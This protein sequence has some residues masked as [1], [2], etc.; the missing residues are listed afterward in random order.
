MPEPT[1]RLARPD[2][3]PA[4]ESLLRA[5]WLPPIQI[6]EFLDTFWVADVNSEAIGAAGIE[7]YED[8]AAVLRSVVVSPT[9]RKTGLGDTLVRTAL[10]YAREHGARRVYLF[11]MHAMPFF[12]HYG[13]QPCTTEDFEPAVRKSWQYLGLTERPE[14]LKQMT[15]M[16]LEISHYLPH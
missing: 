13:F 11:T 7:L 4:I 1:I 6:A 8:G 16:R 3:I 14:I 9:V 10:D 12:A 15:P 5:E 2:D